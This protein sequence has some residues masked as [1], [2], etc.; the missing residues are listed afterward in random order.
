M[1]SI[2]TREL[3]D[4]WKYLN[5]ARPLASTQAY[6]FDMQVDEVL[7]SHSAFVETSDM[8][9]DIEEMAFN[10]HPSARLLTTLF[11]QVKKDRNKQ[12]RKTYDFEEAVSNAFFNLLSN[13]AY[14]VSEFHQMIKKYVEDYNKQFQ[15]GDIPYSS[16]AVEKG[17]CISVNLQIFDFPH[18]HQTLEDLKRAYH[19][20]REQREMVPASFMTVIDLFFDHYQ[21]LECLVNFCSQRDEKRRISA[22]KNTSIVFMEMYEIDDDLVEVV[23]KRLHAMVDMPFKVKDISQSQFDRFKQRFNSVYRELLKGKRSEYDKPIFTYTPDS[24]PTLPTYHQQSNK[25]KKCV[26]RVSIKNTTV[27]SYV[28]PAD[29]SEMNDVK[30]KFVPPTVREKVKT[31]RVPAADQPPADE[32]I[33]LDVPID[34]ASQRPYYFLH[35]QQRE[36]VAILFNRKKGTL[37]WGDIIILLTKINMSVSPCGGSKWKVVDL[38]MNR[39]ATLHAPHP[40]EEGRVDQKNGYKSKLEDQLKITYEYLMEKN[41]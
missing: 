41:N 1:T 32:L 37:K 2:C 14:V 34:T 15:T 20:Y 7:R 33:E 24:Q 3:E 39:T 36:T 40:K 18:V 4:T 17:M 9:M 6:Y 30:E 10:Q 19:K 29:I 35:N 28:D 13:S 31:R 27:M 21:F 22:I 16:R 11:L 12:V 8:E 23:F 26:P 25:E 5:A 38:D